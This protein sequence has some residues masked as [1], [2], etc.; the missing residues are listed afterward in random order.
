MKVFLSFFHKEVLHI[1]RDTRTLMLLLGMPVLLLGLF[2]FAITTEVKDIRMV[3]VEPY[4]NHDPERIV[5]AL[6]GNSLIRVV[7]RVGTISQ[8]EKEL[9]AGRADLAIVFARN[10]DDARQKGQRAELSLLIDDVDPNTSSMMVSIVSNVLREAAMPDVQINLPPYTIVPS[11]EM[12]FNPSMEATYFFVPGVMGLVL[13]LVCALMTGVSIVREKEVGTMEVL[14]VSP[15]RPWIVIVAKTVPYFIIGCINLLCSLLV[16][17]YVLRVPINGSLWLVLVISLLFILV[18]LLF[19]LLVSSF[20]SNQGVATMICGAG[21]MLPVAILSGMLFP[22]DS[23]PT[24]LQY[25][26]T[27]VPATWFIDGIKKVMIQGLGASYVLKHIL[28]L[29]GMILL[30]LL[31]NIKFY[32]VRLD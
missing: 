29:L 24:L 1:M 10:F 11:V 2:G 18:S 28:I 27:V 13:M 21:L 23:M 5:Q 31:V 6:D 19:G 22:V 14:L 12:L 4:G 3:M 8:A 16:S 17:Y 25:V 26:S 7:D 9:E 32:K 15:V 20:T 30:L